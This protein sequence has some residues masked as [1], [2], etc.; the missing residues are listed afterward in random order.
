[1]IN[2]YYRVCTRS[3]EFYTLDL[4]RKFTFGYKLLVSGLIARKGESI[5][6]LKS[7]LAPTPNYVKNWKIVQLTNGKYMRIL[8]LKSGGRRGFGVVVKVEFHDLKN[9]EF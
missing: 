7:P 9:L 3:L 2:G 1:M 6:I 4:M 8:K 5:L